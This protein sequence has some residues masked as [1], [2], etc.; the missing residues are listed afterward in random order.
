MAALEPALR[1][2][3][4]RG[5]TQS[6]K[7]AWFNAYRDTVLSQDGLAWLERVWRRQE[8]VPGLTLAEPDEIALALEL[9][10]REV[11]RWDEILRTQASRT[12]NP[13]RKARFEFVMPAMSADPCS[14]GAGVRTA[15]LRR[16]S[17]ARAVGAR[18]APVSQSPASR[19]ARPAASCP[20]RSA[21]LREIQRT[22]DIFFPTRWM[23]STLGGHTSP[24][25]AGIV[26]DFLANE[27]AVSAAAPVD[28]PHGRRRLVPHC[29][30]VTRR[31]V[32]RWHL[33]R[34][35][36]KRRTLRG[37]KLRVRSPN[38][39]TLHRRSARLS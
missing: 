17:A 16:E 30:P 5:R 36:P 39:T 25:V 26:Q 19:S 2:G 23:E 35:P 12:Q 27:L 18:V 4:E 34:R 3:I 37:P 8:T 6:Q 1:A 20:P 33:S 32:R 7:A 14:S 11:T 38:A 15:R 31:S 13:D 9:A 29:P 28:D 21:L 22:G 24:E 10:V